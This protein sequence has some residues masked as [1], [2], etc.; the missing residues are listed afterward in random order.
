MTQK[1][2]EPSESEGPLF[3]S[4]FP[5]LLPPRYTTFPSP[6]CRDD[7]IGSE[8]WIQL[9]VAAA[10]RKRHNPASLVV[11]D[12][13]T[14]PSTVLGGAVTEAPASPLEWTGTHQSAT[15]EEETVQ[16]TARSVKVRGLDVRK[17]GPKPD[18]EADYEYSVEGPEADVTETVAPVGT[19]HPSPSLSGSFAQAHSYGTDT[20]DGQEG[21]L[22]TSTTHSVTPPALVEKRGWLRK[23]G[24]RIKS[25][26]IRFCVLEYQNLFYYRKEGDSVPRGT[27]S[28]AS[29][30]VVT[31]VQSNRSHPHIFTIAI[32]GET[33]VYVFEAEDEAERRRWVRLLRQAS[34]Q[35]ERS[36]G[37][38]PEGSGS[39]LS[40][41]FG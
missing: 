10:E 17:T 28:L 36:E 6:A 13:V 4:M 29:G 40:M 2:S 23:Q 32:P 9:E 26:R 35:E 34:T 3:C 11:G 19:M 27:I 14:L 30:A 41:M 33:R 5:A 1:R 15:C 8:W 25:W 31:P 12:Y 38:K 39:G 20:G 24:G 21:A 22:T 18:P 7:E 16:F 37:D